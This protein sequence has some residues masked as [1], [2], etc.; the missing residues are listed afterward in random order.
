[1]YAIIN[2]KTKK[3]VC[4]TD[5]RYSPPHQRTSEN[6]LITYPTFFEAVYDMY[7]RRC[8]QDYTVCEIDISVGYI[9]GKKEIPSRRKCLDLIVSECL[10]KKGEADGDM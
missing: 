4:G 8:G 9:Y 3:F 5:Y 2:K 7:H 10:G 6:E 1:M